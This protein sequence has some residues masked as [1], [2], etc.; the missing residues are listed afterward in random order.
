MGIV[1]NNGQNLQQTLVVCLPDLPVLCK[2]SHRGA[3]L[4][5]VL[6]KGGADLQYVGLSGLGNH[7][8]VVQWS[9]YRALGLRLSLWRL[10]GLTLGLKVVTYGRKEARE[11]LKSSKL[12][13]FCGFC[14]TSLNIY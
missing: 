11:I 9:R 2:G 6:W 12:K 4:C 14:S 13:A 1:F 5:V 3:L 10:L 8:G 7:H